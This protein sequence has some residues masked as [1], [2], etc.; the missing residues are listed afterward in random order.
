LIV[1]EIEP[2]P[3]LGLVENDTDAS[4]FL[5][6]ML[7]LAVPLLDNVRVVGDT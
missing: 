4:C 6:V 3:Q 7:K 5:T 2:D 1:T